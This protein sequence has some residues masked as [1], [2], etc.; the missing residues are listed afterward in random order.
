MI[1]KN[2]YN[3]NKIYEIKSLKKLKISNT[4]FIN[5]LMMNIK[6]ENNNLNSINFNNIIELNE[7]NDFINF[8]KILSKNKNLEELFLDCKY[9]L[10]N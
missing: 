2:E 3:F 4:K 7:K 9:L 10:F 8:S 5:D 1:N 6:E